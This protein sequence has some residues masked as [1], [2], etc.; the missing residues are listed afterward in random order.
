MAVAV[1][2][3]QMFVIGLD[4]DKL[5]GQVARELHRASEKGNIRILDVLAIQRTNQGGVV[6][7]GGSD[8]S[9]DQRMEYGAIIGGLMGFGATG[10]EEGLEVGAEVGAEKFATH[11]FGLTADDIQAMAQDVPPGT[12]AVIA[13]IEHLWAIPLKEAVEDAGG[14]VLAQGMVRPE[15]LMALGEGMAATV[16]VPD[17]DMSQGAQP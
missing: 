11:N 5:R 14:V 1:G 2:P 9:P 3:V 7:L 6:S 8:L 16:P 15:S 10:T 13:L 12:T 4:N 17:V